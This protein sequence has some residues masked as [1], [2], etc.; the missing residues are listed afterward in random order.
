MSRHWL[1][2]AIAG[3]A[4]GCAD[5]RVSRSSKGEENEPEAT[6]AVEVAAMRY[7]QRLDRTGHMP[8]NALW[9]AKLRRDQMPP[10][11]SGPADTGWTWVG[12]GN[13]GG[14]IR[15]ILV[16]PADP[17]TI[18]IGAATGGVWKTTTGGT[19]WSPCPNFV[20]SLSIG[21][22]VLDPND[23][24]VL[25]VG[26]GEGVFD[27]V[28]GTSN[29]AA[30]RGA[31]IFKSTDGGATWAQLPSTADANWYFVNRLSFQPGSNQV[32][33]AATETGIWRTTDAGVTW[34]QRTTDRTLDIQ[35]DPTDGTKAVAG[36]YHGIAQFSTDSGVTWAN[37]TGIPSTSHRVE[38]TYAPSNTSIVYAGVS[39]GEGTTT[40]SVYRSGDGG[41]T[42][43]LRGGSVQQ[44]SSYTGVLWVDPLNSDSILLGAVNLYRSTNGGTTLSTA[45]SGMHTDNHYIAQHPLYDGTTNKILFFGTD[46]GIFK[47]TDSGTNTSTSLVTGLGITQFY[48]AAIS[49]ASGVIVAGAQDNGTNRYSGNPQAWARNVIGGDGGFCA[50]DPTDPNYFYGESQRL[51]ISRSIN[52]GASFSTSVG[53]GIADAGTLNCNFIPY[54]LLDPNNPSRMLAA[55]RSLWRTNNV[56]TGAP[57]AWTSIKPPLLFGP[58][59]PPGKPPQDH[60]LDNDPRNISTI[61]IAEG[62]SDLIW[63]GHNNGQLYM[64]TNGTAAAPTWTRVDTN[65]PAWPGRWISRVVIDR[66][67]PSHVLVS[68][69]G[70]STDNVWRTLDAGLTWQSIGGSGAGQLPAVSV[71]ALA[72]HRLDPN[73][74]FA[75]TDVGMFISTD[76]GGSWAPTAPELGPVEIQEL[77]WRNNTTLMA[78]TYGRGVYLG[79]ATIPSCYANCDGSTSVPVLNVN[80]FIC[81]QTRFASGDT[82]AN[83]DGST[84]IPVL[85]VNDFICFQSAFAAGCQ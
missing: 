83:C 43:V 58:P 14:R 77:I 56:K 19:T 33:L 80:D 79:D 55:G 42:Y 50:S 60:Y 73:R 4:A 27:T 5:E 66:N 70:Y 13:V 24:N 51:A 6:G 67:N 37:A 45:Y 20:P 81:F 44:L 76:A 23:P 85:T 15:S 63:V 41:Q 22:M 1:I 30:V 32:M 49:D 8:D 16:S 72:Q 26:T 71:G 59:P 34:S 11:R 57:P 3:L 68:M 10:A 39:A 35:F 25:Y 28:E 46:G 52:G 17:N 31:G 29:S 7:Y 78:V 82:Y 69:L 62:N 54:F 12:P 61:A 75:G 21:C 36:E 38:L 9:T 47:T 84:S 74:L 40:M 18:W 2:A 53:S 64:T 48:G 65:A